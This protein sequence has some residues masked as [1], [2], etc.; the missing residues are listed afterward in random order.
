MASVPTERTCRTCSE[1]AERIFSP[2]GLSRLGSGQATAIGEAERSAH[3]P[4]VVSRVPN[5]ATAA[6]PRITRDPRHLGL[7]RP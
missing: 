7:P 6:P 5:S 2:V 1:T 3:E 4:D